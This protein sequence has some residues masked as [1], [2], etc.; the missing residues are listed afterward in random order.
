MILFF[1]TETTGLPNKNKPIADASQPRLVQI[2][3]VLLDDNMTE[4]AILY[5]V[6]KPNGFIIP[7]E[8]ARIHGITTA[9]AHD[10]GLHA[11]SVLHYFN[12]MWE[13]ADLIV[14]HNTA[15]DLHILGTE[16]ALLSFTLEKRPSYCTMLHATP[17]L[18][19][20][21]KYSG[22]K[23]PR[24]SECIKFFFH[25]DLEGVHDAF[26]DVRATIRLYVKLQELSKVGDQS[27]AEEQG[28]DQ[29]I[30]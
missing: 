21:G 18:K 22:Y 5:A 6:V 23:W 2:A 20:P 30:S 25:E 11:R 15:Y 17:I 24:L 9:C 26:V 29:G 27:G 12:K 3:A 14:C 8:A 7:N 28:L 1:D 10:F 19:L 4:R 13:R 16:F